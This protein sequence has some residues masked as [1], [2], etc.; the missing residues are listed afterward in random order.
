M[1]DDISEIR[2]FYEALQGRQVAARLRPKVTDFWERS[3]G[4]CNIAIGFATPFLRQDDADSVLMPQRQGV[5]V[6]PHN[7]PVLSLIHI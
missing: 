2:A 1:Y 7:Q 4:C 3:A 6:W 5:V